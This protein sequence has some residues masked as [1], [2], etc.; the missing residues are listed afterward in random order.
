MISEVVNY[1]F[2]SRIMFHELC[3]NNAGYKLDQ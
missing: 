1:C 3:N 2:T